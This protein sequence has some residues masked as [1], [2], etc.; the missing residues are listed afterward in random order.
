MAAEGNRIMTEPELNPDIVQAVIDKTHEFQSRDEIIMSE[1]P[2]SADE[3]WAL[4]MQSDYSGD[5]YYQELKGLIED[6]E[7]DQQTTLV[8][9]MWLGRGDY[10]VDEWEEALEYAG[11]A[12]N[13]HTAD[14]LI[15]TPLLSDYL[16]DAL[17]QFENR[18][19]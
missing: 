3:D 19:D 14:Y 7:P 16:A 9:M 12:W 5:P 6:L 1:V 13:E 18:E 17:E 10:S 11:E 4:Q 2:E 8:A 15:G